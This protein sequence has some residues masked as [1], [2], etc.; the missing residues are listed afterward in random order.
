VSIDFSYP[1]LR[2]SLLLAG[3]AL[4]LAAPLRSGLARDAAPQ[5]LRLTAEPARAQL[6]G[7]DHPPT[8]VWAYDGRIPDPTLRLR[9]GEPVRFLIENRLDQG[10]TVH[11]HGIRLPN[12]MDGVPGPTQP[13]IS[14][15]ALTGCRTNHPSAP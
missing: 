3:A 11:W 8:D 2:R 5:E 15:Y 6:A 9:Q 13:A 7:A 14:R 12:A 4:A 10:T 1:V